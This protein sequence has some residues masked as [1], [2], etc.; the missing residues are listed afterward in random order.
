[1]D[2][3]SSTTGMKIT[4]GTTYYE[5]PDYLYRFIKLYKDKVDEIIIVDDYSTKFKLET[6]FEPEPSVKLYKVTKD[7]GFNS[8][9]SRNLIMNQAKNDWVCLIDVDRE[10]YNEGE[11]IL[12]IYEK[13]LSKEVL[14]KFSAHFLQYGRY[15]HKSV[16][17]F[18]IH[19]ELFYKVG[20]Y[21][22]ECIGYR[23][24]DRQLFEQISNFAR[25][26]ALTDINLILTRPATKTKK[27]LAEN[28]PKRSLLNKF[29]ETFRKR[30]LHPEKDKKTLTFDWEQIF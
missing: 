3:N 7:Y 4:L 28:P 25:I 5:N 27:N 11:D 18:L 8:H 15:L 30:E 23:T 19:K 13:E 14:Y 26:E 20:G 22:E 6:L 2:K 17:D 24:G 9:G 16:N 29:E 21:D 12:K 1:M 10:F